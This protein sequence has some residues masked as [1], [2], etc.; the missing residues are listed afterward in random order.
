MPH[1]PKKLLHEMKQATD[2][3]ARY[4]EKRTFE[5]YLSDDFLRSAVERQFEI[6]GEA[7]TRL[8][9]ASPELAAHFT[10]QTKISGFR[11]SLIHGYDTIDHRI[12]WNIILV[13]LP[14]LR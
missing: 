6:V 2:R 13:H 8:R 14:V 5:D 9:Q 11:N 4:T 12:T 1:D 3:I 10:D 7:M